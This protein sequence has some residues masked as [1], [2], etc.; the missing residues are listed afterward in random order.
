MTTTHGYGADLNRAEYKADAYETLRK[1][2]DSKTEKRFQEYIKNEMDKN[3]DFDFR[4]WKTVED[5]YL[6]RFIMRFH[7]YDW[8][9]H[10]FEGLLCQLINNREFGSDSPVF[11]YEEDYL[12]VP[13]EIPANEDEKK[14]MLTKEQ[15]R[16][17]L[18]K[19]LSLLVD[20]KDIIICDIEIATYD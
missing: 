20:E 3:P 6:T 8:D 19:Y 12:Y 4:I 9:W 13:A 11:Y 5:K 10:G 16:T 18:Y 1:I 14:K 15:I 2:F 17:I 7:N